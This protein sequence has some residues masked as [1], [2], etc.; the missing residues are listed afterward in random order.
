VDA[1]GSIEPL[2]DPLAA[3]ISAAGLAP[4][5]AAVCLAATAFGADPGAVAASAGVPTPE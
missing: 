5:V 3:A 4:D 2:A 1:P